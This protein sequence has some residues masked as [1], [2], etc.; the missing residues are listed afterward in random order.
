MSGTE[1]TPSATGVEGDATDPLDAY[2]ASIA[3]E[4][5]HQAPIE[6]GDIAQS[7]GAPPTATIAAHVPLLPYEGAP[8]VHPRPSSAAQLAIAQKVASSPFCD[9][10]RRGGGRI[11][12]GSIVDAEDHDSQGGSGSNEA[13]EA[14]LALLLDQPADF[15]R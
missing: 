15:L 11:R 5:T 8:F 9:V 4:I 13:R 2:M 7:P 12:G 14:C 10:L 1:A 6:G 3:S